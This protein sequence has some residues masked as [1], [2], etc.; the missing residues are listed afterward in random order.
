LKALKIEKFQLL[1]SKPYRPKAK[2]KNQIWIVREPFN[3]LSVIKTLIIIEYRKISKY[4]S[5]YLV[6]LKFVNIMDQ[7]N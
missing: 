6:V 1:N 7:I 3:L 2:F 5:L 4:F